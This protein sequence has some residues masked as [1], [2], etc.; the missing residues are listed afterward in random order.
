MSKTLTSESPAQV[1]TVPS[2][3]CGIN[4]TENMLAEWPVST[5]VFS[6][7]GLADSAGIYC[8]ML[9]YVSSDPDASS[10]PLEDQLL[11]Y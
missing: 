4:F 10:R 5:P 7:N 1:T 11:K 9:R 8:H 2:L 3:E 6:V